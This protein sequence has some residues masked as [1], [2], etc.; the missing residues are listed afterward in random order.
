MGIFK[1]SLV[2]M[3][4]VV[5]LSQ[6]TVARQRGTAQPQGVREATVG[7]IPGVVAAGAVWTRAWQGTDNADGLVASDDGGLLFAQEQPNQV[8]KLDRN[9]RVSVF[10]KDTHGAGALSI[11]SRG[12]ILA[13]QRTCTD[14]GRNAAGPCNEPTA[15]AVLA[16]ERK[17]LADGIDGRPLGRLNDLVAAKNGSVYFTS[18]GAFRLDPAGHVTSL[19]ENIRANGIMLSRDERV[20]Y[21]TNGNAVVAFDVQPDGTTTGRRDFATLEAGGAGDGMTIDAD[22][23][24]YVTSNPGVQVFGADGKYLGVIPAPRASISVAF[25]GAGKKTL[26]VVGSGALGA[27]GQEVATAA[28][29]RNNAKTIYRLPMIASGFRGRAK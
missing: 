21:V 13:V 3:I 10:L 23:R 29:V 18:S 20:L 7:A 12:R 25:S 27:N 4:P 24:L 2:V 14:P 28:G 11:D 6:S 8:S 9:D 1:A 15:I 17:T 22:G 5:A 19:G 16:P 26:Y